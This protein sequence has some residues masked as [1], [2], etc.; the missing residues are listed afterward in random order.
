MT[1]DL[2]HRLVLGAD[3]G[4]LAIT[5][6]EAGELLTMHTRAAVIVNGNPVELHTLPWHILPD[7]VDDL[8]E[9]DPWR[10]Q[11]HESLVKGLIDG[12]DQARLFEVAERREADR[13]REVEELSRRFTLSAGALAELRD[14][15]G[16]PDA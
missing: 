9:L 10:A 4:S 8:P 15:F 13:L 2:A 7:T 3:A 14:L 11:A 1:P 6:S 5:R 16:D 12:A